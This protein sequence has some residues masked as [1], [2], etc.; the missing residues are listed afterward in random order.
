M[1]RLA[2]IGALVST[3]LAHA[4]PGP[5]LADATQ[6][7]ES[8]RDAAL[9]DHETRLREVEK[10]VA[11]QKQTRQELDE[12][13]WLTRF[14]S[15]YID[16]G[17]FVVGGDGSG[18]RSDYLHTNF[19]E[20]RDAIAG[21]WVFMGDPFTT[22]INSLG[23]PADTAAS[24]E[25]ATDTV[26]S[27]G[28]P[29]FMV[30]TLGIAFG[31]DVGHGFLISALAQFLPRPGDDILDVPFA[32]ITYRPSQQKDFYLEIG[33]IESVLGLEYRT[34]DAPRR[35]T[36][37]PSLI[38]RYTCGRP[39]GLAARL[40]EDVGASQF[41]AA[42]ALTN[43]NNFE[44]RFEPET[45][46][47]SSRIPTLSGHLLWKLN[48]GSAEKP[49]GLEL[50]ASAAIGPQDAQPD[51]DV[52]QWHYGFDVRLG[53]IAGFT[54][55]GEFVHGKQQGSTAGTPM[56]RNCDLAPCLTYKGAYV[57]VERRMDRLTPYVRVDW[58]DAVHRN[59]TTYIYDANSVRTT[60]GAQFGWTKR[61]LAKA[62]Y[63]L[64]RELGVPHFPH[65][66]LTASLVVSTE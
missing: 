35:L 3:R 48:V 27:G 47:R 63:N 11:A 37:T 9:E 25:V 58:R 60:I 21:Q 16:V 52:H 29:S 39:L 14:I 5:P 17:A 62:E 59:G 18:I 19:P 30:N 49:I 51:T 44:E 57:L 61:I 56:D 15:I 53:E 46:L 8:E 54:F 28:H 50:G 33:K 4:Q 34:Q 65:D 23:E 42:L 12:L 20:Y 66:V 1:K 24:R 22:M 43:G 7:A 32:Y 40:V 10:Q 38:C 41:N 64:N 26:N 6:Q 36:V 45:S 13:R 31:K 55:T 2:I